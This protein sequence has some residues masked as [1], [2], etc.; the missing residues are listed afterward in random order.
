MKYLSMLLILML[1]VPCLADD[2][3]FMWTAEKDGNTIHLL[4]SIHAGQSS[5]YPL[6]DRIEQAFA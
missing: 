2:P 5:W 6:D 3:L 4:G 1:A